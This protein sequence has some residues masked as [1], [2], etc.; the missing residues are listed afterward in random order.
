MT[1]PG[2]FNFQAAHNY[3]AQQHSV[4]VSARVDNATF[5]NPAFP[6]SHEN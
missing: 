1:T 6:D 5:N 3:L 4:E 2:G